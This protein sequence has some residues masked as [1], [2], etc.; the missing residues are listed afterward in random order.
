MN[1]RQL[2]DP[3]S[4]SE[5]LLREFLVNGWGSLSKR[6][7]DLLL[8][9]LLEKD[10]AL[11][12]S[13]SNYEVA[14][15]LRLTESRVALLRKDAYARWRLLNPEEPQSVLKRIFQSSLTEKKLEHVM[16]FSTERRMNEGFIPLLIEHPDD[17]AEME[18]AIK[19]AGGIPIHERNREVVLIPHT[20]LLDIADHHSLLQDDPEQIRDELAQIAREVDQ[21]LASDTTLKEFLQMPLEKITPTAIRAAFNDAGATVAEHSLKT[22]PKLIRLWLP[23]IP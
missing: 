4:F 15:V 13:A 6:D 1:P 11:D 8:F 22:M 9:I 3:A 10:G 14:R 18:R 20:L 16:K 23:C 2:S 19:V 21:I 5:A 17:R 7:L 12:R